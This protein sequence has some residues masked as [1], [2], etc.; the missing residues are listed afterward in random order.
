MRYRQIKDP[1][2]GKYS[3]V[4]A[5]D[6]ARAAEGQIIVKGKFDAFKSPIDGSEIRTQRQ[7]DDHCRKHNVVPSAEFNKEFVERKQKERERLFKG[8]HT[9]AEKHRRKCEVNEIIN[10]LERRT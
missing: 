2:T 6:A 10:Y 9:E 7:Y 1:D 4:P 5:D 8:E 3:L